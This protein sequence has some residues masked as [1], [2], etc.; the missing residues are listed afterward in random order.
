MLIAFL[1]L[2]T[3]GLMVWRT[4]CCKKEENL[5]F[6]AANVSIIYE[7][8]HS[9]KRKVYKQTKIVAAKLQGILNSKFKIQN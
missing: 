6:H 3:F 4:K 1:R 8:K 5:R 2:A 7:K 9:P